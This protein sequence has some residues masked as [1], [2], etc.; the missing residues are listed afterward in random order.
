MH[1]LGSEKDHPDLCQNAIHLGH[2]GNPGWGVANVRLAVV[3]E[4]VFN[5]NIC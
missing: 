1:L 4:Q 2:N 5:I 3:I